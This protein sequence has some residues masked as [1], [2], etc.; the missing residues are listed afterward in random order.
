MLGPP[1]CKTCWVFFFLQSVPK[2]KGVCWYRCPKCDKWMDEVPK[3]SL[4][5]VSKREG[6]KVERNTNNLNS[7]VFYSHPLFYLFM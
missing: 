1:I 3:T 5:C 7:G 6:E 2:N 4:Y